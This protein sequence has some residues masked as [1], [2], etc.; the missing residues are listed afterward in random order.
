MRLM[1]GQLTLATQ[2]ANL[3][4]HSLPSVSRRECESDVLM[5]S[6]CCGGEGGARVGQHGAEA[7]CPPGKLVERAGRGDGRAF[8]RLPLETQQRVLRL[9]WRLLGSSEDARDVGQ[10][11]YLRVFR[12][13]RRFR[14]EWSVADAIH[15]RFRPLGELGCPPVPRVIRRII[16]RATLPRRHPP[17]S[18]S[19]FRRQRASMTSDYAAA[20]GRLIS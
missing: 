7:T 11:I 8:D 17:P 5:S 12:H 16:C 14:A 10:E 20:K 3:L 18:S 1:R 6:R 15:E 4:Q 9:A 2:A 19:S 13:L